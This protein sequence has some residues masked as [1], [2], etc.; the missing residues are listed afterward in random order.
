MLTRQQLEELRHQ[1]YC[2]YGYKKAYCD[3]NDCCE[4]CDR[5]IRL[6]CRIISKIED[7]QT[8]RILKICP[9]DSVK[10]GGEK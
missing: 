9:S 6:G 2:V 3:G 7:W 1:G 4:N 10:T 8:K 5:V